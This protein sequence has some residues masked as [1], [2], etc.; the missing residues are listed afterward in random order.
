[1]LFGAGNPRP[2]KVYIFGRSGVLWT[3]KAKLSGGEASDHFGWSLAITEGAQ[4]TLVVGAPGLEK[5]GGVGGASVFLGTGT[6]WPKQADLVPS[7]GLSSGDAFGFSVG[8]SENTAIVGASGQQVGGAVRAGAAYVFTR[9]GGTWTQQARLV[10]ND[11]GAGDEFG[12]A[13]DI[14]KNL[15]VVGSP[16]RP[17]SAAGQA[18]VFI[19]TGT[20]WHEQEQ[21]LKANPPEPF[22]FFGFSVSVDGT[23]IAVGAPFHALGAAPGPAYVFA[24]TVSLAALWIGLQNSDAVGLRID[25]RTEVYNGSTLVAEGQANGVRTGSSGFNNAILHT[26]PL[27]VL[28]SPFTTYTTVIVSA[29]VSCYEPGHLSGVARLWYNGRFI[30]TGPTQDAGSR[31]QF[32]QMTNR[33][34]RNDDGALRLKTHAGTDRTSLDLSLNSSAPCPERPFT[35]FPAFSSEAQSSQ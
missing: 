26:V 30:D 34:L 14:D 19:R 24:P 3:A 9:S 31:I 32:H 1:V 7:T 29:R 17:P 15:A 22:Q 35:T 4:R 6:S 28:T 21:Q 18:Y 16:F 11:G 5:P 27:E 13:V 8:V 33:F 10:A 12:S 20:V 23:N 2:G 25:L